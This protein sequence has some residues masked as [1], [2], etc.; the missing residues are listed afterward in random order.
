MSE[1]LTR[2]SDDIVRAAA[3][4]LSVQREGGYHR[5]ARSVGRGSAKLKARH[6][7]KKLRNVAI[8][9]G[10]V[11]LGASVIG[12]VLGGLGFPGVMLA[13]AATLGAV[14][15]FGRYPK[16]RLPQ[17]PDLQTENVRDLVGKT[18]LWLE[19]QRDKLPK[20]TAKSLSVIGTQLDDLQAQLEEVDQKHPTA[21]E[22][23]K[24]IGQDL[25]AMISGFLKIPEKLRY[26]ERAGSTPAR[27]LDEGLE[28]VSREI[29][30]ITRQLAEGSLDDLAI[31]HRYLDYKYGDGIE[32]ISLDDEGAGQ[33]IDQGTDQGSGVPLNLD[34]EK[35]KS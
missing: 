9:I 29:D 12:W 4:S 3:Q 13:G 14:Y 32:A 7:V 25:P 24:L 17:L 15:L 21:G 23:R 10:A 11:W 5:S 18:E 26:E 30:S 22:V 35:A 28:V 1:D 16:M 8:A 20:P 27:Q 31:R 34:R 6:W 2:Q 33:S 19:M